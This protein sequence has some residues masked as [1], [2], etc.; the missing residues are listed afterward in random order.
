MDIRSM[1]CIPQRLHRDTT[2]VSNHILFNKNSCSSVAQLLLRVVFKSLQ[3]RPEKDIKY[4]SFCGFIFMYLNGFIIM[5]SIL[6]IY[7]S[8]VCLRHFFSCIRDSSMYK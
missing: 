8:I 4:V 7:S 1:E 5:I 3:M 6:N 2:Y